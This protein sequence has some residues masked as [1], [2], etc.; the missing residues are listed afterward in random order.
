[1]WGV[2]QISRAIHQMNIF[3]PNKKRSWRLCKSNENK[4]TQTYTYHHGTSFWFIVYVL[5]GMHWP[6]H[7]PHL[8]SIYTKLLNSIHLRIMLYRIFSCVERNSLCFCCYFCLSSDWYQIHFNFNIIPA[9]RS[10][11]LFCTKYWWHP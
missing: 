6:I 5:Y 7:T 3:C 8:S 9:I 4:R 11:W 1:M 10:P 2:F